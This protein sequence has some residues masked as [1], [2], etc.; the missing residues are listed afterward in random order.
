[1]NDVKPGLLLVGGL[2]VLALVAC[3]DKPVEQ[4]HQLRVEAAVQ[5]PATAL[6]RWYSDQQVVRGG[7]LFQEH[8]ASC[9]MADASGT[10]EWKKPDAEG[11]YPPPPL[12][13]TAHAWHH[14][15]SVLGRTVR[16]GGVRLGG[17]MPPFRDKLNDQ[18]IIDLLAWV[19]SHWS[20]K[21]YRVWSERNAQASKPMQPMKK[22]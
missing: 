16:N 12:N 18:Q 3:S 4:P 5:P 17:S 6:T 10:K 21:I 8:C 11:K 2:S 14:P 13:G 20:D 1:M 22:G 7:P 19:Q 15:L 9:H